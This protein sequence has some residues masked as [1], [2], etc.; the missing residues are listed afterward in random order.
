MY[1]L[2]FASPRNSNVI[3]STPVAGTWD[4]LTSTIQRL[5][6][7]EPKSVE[8]LEAELEEYRIYM[9]R[10]ML[11]LDQVESTYVHN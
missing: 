5:T 7:P 3:T 6:A 8:Q 10:E 11:S 2:S 9:E 1:P 4:F